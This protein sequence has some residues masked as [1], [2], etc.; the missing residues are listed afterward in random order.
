MKATKV[1]ETACPLL[2]HSC[3]ISLMMFLITLSACA[4]DILEKESKLSFYWLPNQNETCF[5]NTSLKLE[6]LMI[7]ITNK[8]SS[9]VKIVYLS[10]YRFYAN[11]TLIS[12]IG[13]V[14]TEFYFSNLKKSASSSCIATVSRKIFTLKFLLLLQKRSP[15]ERKKNMA[16][17]RK[18]KIGKR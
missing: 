9:K 5:S 3:A 12:T 16:D 11:I 18:R 15:P 4:L 13:G 8:N 7:I 14:N 6:Y 2:A 10:L 1:S 17:L